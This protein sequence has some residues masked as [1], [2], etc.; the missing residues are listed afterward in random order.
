[1]TGAATPTLSRAQR[2]ILAQ[3]LTDAILY[4]DPPVECPDCEALATLCPQC[5][6]GLSRARGY[7]T[8]SRQL[9]I[10]PPPAIRPRQLNP[11]SC[12]RASR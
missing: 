8:L 1:M 3:A 11:Q 10:G 9:G 5:A 12:R 6:A 7:L 2:D 4:R